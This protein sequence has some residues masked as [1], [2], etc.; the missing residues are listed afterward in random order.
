MNTYHPPAT[1][2]ERALDYAAA[3]IGASLGVAVERSGLIADPVPEPTE[4]TGLVVA[5]ATGAWTETGYLIGA[6]RPYEFDHAAVLQILTTGGDEAARLSRRA[7]ALRVVADLVAADPSLGGHVDF[8]ELVSPDPD[9]EA[10]FAGVA[11]TLSL[12]FTAP[13]ALG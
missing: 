13:D 9:E 1:V 11:A 12:T 4:E 2:A 3:L 8:A 6:E 10:R 5:L 7:D